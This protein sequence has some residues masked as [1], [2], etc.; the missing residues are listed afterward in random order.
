MH[1]NTQKHMS[2]DCG[3]EGSGFE[4]R[5]SPSLLQDKRQVPAESPG[6]WQQQG[7]SSEKMK[8]FDNVERTY[9]GYR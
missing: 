3:S 6:A 8:L 2:A 7:N 4:P 9:V 5:R 1:S